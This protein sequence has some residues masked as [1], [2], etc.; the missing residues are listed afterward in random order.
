VL[1]N[2]YLSRQS[3]RREGL[4]QN[5]NFNEEKILVMRN[6][7]LSKLLR[8]LSIWVLIT[9]Q[10]NVYK[11]DAE[12]CIDSVPVLQFAM[13]WIFIEALWKKGENHRMGSYSAQ[14]K[15]SH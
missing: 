4:V 9:E 3:D 11:K 10:N 14:P 13:P 15:F 6:S 5:I 2:T 7:L 1:C 8:Q 12:L